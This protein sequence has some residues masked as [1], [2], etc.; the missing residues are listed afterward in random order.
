MKRQRFFHAIVF[1]E[2]AAQQHFL[3]KLRRRVFAL[4]QQAQ[5]FFVEGRIF[6]RRQQFARSSFVNEP[7]E[8]FAARRAQVLARAVHRRAS[9]LPAIWRSA[10]RA[11]V[12]AASVRT[13]PITALGNARRS[14][15]SS[16]W[17][18]N[19]ERPTVP[20]VFP[21]GNAS[22]AMPSDSASRKVI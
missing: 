17:S 9:S 1:Q 4:Q 12:S 20:P 15:I 11:A 5:G 2:V 22:P 18:K 6:Q 19:C 8:F 10:M 14:S 3:Q 7:D 16:A 13:S 21:S